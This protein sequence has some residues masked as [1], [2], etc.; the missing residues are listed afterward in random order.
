MTSIARTE[1]APLIKEVNQFSPRGLIVSHIDP[2]DIV[3]LSSICP[4]ISL[5]VWCILTFYHAPPFMISLSMLGYAF[6]DLKVMVDPTI[7][8]IITGDKALHGLM[9]VRHHLSPIVTHSPLRTP[10]LLRMILVML[11]LMVYVLFFL[12]YASSSFNPIYTLSLILCMVLLFLSL[13]TPF[14]LL[15]TSI[16]RL[17]LRV[18]NSKQGKYLNRLTYHYPL[19]C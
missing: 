10:L 12:W 6:R 7:L 8:W 1:D 16:Y 19:Q 3:T 13:S 5:L 15:L 17:L 4:T 18:V 11:M 14:S 9:T 2:Y